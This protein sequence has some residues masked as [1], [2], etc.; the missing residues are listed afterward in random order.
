MHSG[1]VLGRPHSIRLGQR[2]SPRG[3]PEGVQVW[4]ARYLRVS[5]PLM[6]PVHQRNHFQP[7]RA[8]VRPLLVPL[9]ARYSGVPFDPRRPENSRNR[10]REKI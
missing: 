1:V 2:L 7:A 4:S 10:K 3:I 9:G 5:V 6:L 8:R